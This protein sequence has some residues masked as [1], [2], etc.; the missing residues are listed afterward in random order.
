MAC[1]IREYVNILLHYRNPTLL[2]NIS[3]ADVGDKN[4][5]AGNRA[6]VY[7]VETSDMKQPLDETLGGN[8]KVSFTGNAAP[9]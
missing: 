9:Q 4:N 5:K 8:K 3:S 1:I 6:I 2:S 7:L